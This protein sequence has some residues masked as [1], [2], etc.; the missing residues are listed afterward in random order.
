MSKSAKEKRPSASQHVQHDYKRRKLSQSTKGQAY[1]GPAIRGDA[2]K[3]KTVPL[4]KRLE[5][6]EGF[7]GLEEIEDVEVV[8]DETNHHVMFRPKSRAAVDEGSNNKE[9]DEEWEGFDDDGGE[10]KGGSAKPVQP[11]SS[12]KETLQSSKSAK[13]L[14]KQKPKPK[15]KQ[16]EDVVS[17]VK[18]DVLLDSLEDPKTDVSAWKGLDLSPTSLSQLSRLG[19]ARPTPIQAASIPPIMQGHDVIGKAVTGSGKTLA[20]GIPIFEH[21]LSSDNTVS[22]TSAKSKDSVLALIL[23]PTRELALQLNRHLNELCIGLEDHPKVVAVTGGLSIYKQHRQLEHA[24]IVVATPGRLWEVMND[25]SSD[26]DVDA[27]V[28]RLKKIRFLVVDEADRM[29]SEGHFKEVESIL[30]ALDRMI[31]DDEVDQDDAAEE[32]PSSTRQTLVFSA[33][34]HKG[35]HQR[36]TGKLKSVS[37]KKNDNNLLT[38]Q[39][40]MEYLLQKLSFREQKPTFVDVNPTTQMAATLAE[41]IVECPAMK[42][43]LFLYTLLIQHPNKKTLVFTNSISAVKRVTALLQ[44]LKQPAVGLHSTMP[45]KSRLRSLERFAAQ[46]NILVATDVAARGL[47]IKGIELIIHYH[48]PRTADMYVHR[49]G[50]TARAE[51]S[52]QSI[53]LCSPDE[54]AGVRRLIAEVHKSDEAPETIQL[55]G[56][57]MQ[58]LEPHVLLAQRITEATQAKEKTSSKEDWLRSAAEELGVDYDSEEFESQGQRGKRGRGGGRIKKEKD[59]A[60]ISKEQL[61]QW[62][63]ELDALLKKRINLGVSERYLAGGQVDVEALL[64]GRTDG[65]FLEGR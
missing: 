24:D 11:S 29:L 65:V 36:L 50:R 51:M 13:D 16:E 6:A 8:R 47:D 46:S 7:F 55:E 34:F 4:P 61:A 32:S 12:S 38:N 62:R 41:S 15:P 54:V 37:R 40:S 48:V 44:T 59:N 42:K 22:K 58:R 39:Q 43:D 18:F 9:L 28:E 57:L 64:Q 52:G 19:F 1:S 26:Y 33:T 2:L 21:W 45:Q 14:D 56:R 27:L 35:L 63:S 23:A 60:A 49:S 10:T 53:L 3:W 17:N 20:F 5:D 31:V 30:D 25:A